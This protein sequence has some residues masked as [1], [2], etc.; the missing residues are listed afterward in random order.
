[1]S[2]STSDDLLCGGCKKIISSD[3]IERVIGSWGQF[4]DNG[5]DKTEFYCPFCGFEIIVKIELEWV[6]YHI[7]IEKVE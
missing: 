2:I 5:Y 4:N 6:D 3:D 7:S 1:M